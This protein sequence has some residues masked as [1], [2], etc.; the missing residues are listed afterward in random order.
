MAKR[1]NCSLLILFLTVSTGLSSCTYAN[2]AYYSY[3]FD[4]SDFTMSVCMS[5][6]TYIAE[7]ASENTDIKNG[8]VIDANIVEHYNLIEHEDEILPNAHEYVNDNRRG[9]DFSEDDFWGSWHPPRNSEFIFVTNHDHSIGAHLIR[10]GDEFLGFTLEKIYQ[11][12]VEIWGGEPG[13]QHQGYAVLTGDVTIA[14]NIFIWLSN[15]ADTEFSGIVYI[16]ANESYFPLLPAFIG[17]RDTHLR[18]EFNISN[19]DE[20][21][22]YFGIIAPDVDSYLRLVIEDVTMRIS[23]ITLIGRRMDCITHKAR[24]EILPS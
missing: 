24:V 17:D 8:D 5:Y 15:F 23:E 7:I 4:S 18:A 10:E 9:S 14:G 16:S 19:K 3:D 20:V 6:N 21:L 11:S 2:Q 13:M 22:E 1:I 12:I